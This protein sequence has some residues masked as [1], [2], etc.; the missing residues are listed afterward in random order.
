M[1]KDF[2]TVGV[3]IASNGKEDWVTLDFSGGF[4]CKKCSKITKE[5]RDEMGWTGPVQSGS[6][7]SYVGRLRGL[8]GVLVSVVLMAV[9]V[10][11]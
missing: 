5:N 4:N 1:K 9:F 6:S 3:G 11:F 2:K 7:S 8:A 10:R